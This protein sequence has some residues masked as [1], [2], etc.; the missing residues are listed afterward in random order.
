MLALAGGG[1]PPALVASA[2]EFILEGLHLTKRLNKDAAGGPGHLP[3]PGMSAVTW[4]RY[5]YR[6]WDGTQD[7]LRATTPTTCWPS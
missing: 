2:V 7:R 1:G 6:R 3:G 4:P 5:D